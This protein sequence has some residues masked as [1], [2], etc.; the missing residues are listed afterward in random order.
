MKS[1]SC[2]D[3]K[4]YTCNGI[5]VTKPFHGSIE[6]LQPFP[7]T[8]ENLYCSAIQMSLNN[9]V[10]NASYCNHFDYLHKKVVTNP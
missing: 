9:I 7:L 1:K 4:Y 8:R 10:Q 5:I 6:V 2:K 3:C